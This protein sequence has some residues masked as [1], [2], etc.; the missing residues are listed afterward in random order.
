MLYGISKFK[1]KVAVFLLLSVPV[2]IPQQVIQVVKDNMRSIDTHRIHAVRTNLKEVFPY[3]INSDVFGNFIKLC[4]GIIFDI[5]AISFRKPYQEFGNPVH[6]LWGSVG[7]TQGGLHHNI[8]LGSPII[9]RCPFAGTGELG[10]PVICFLLRLLSGNI[11]ALQ[12]PF[13]ISAVICVLSLY[14]VLIE[15]VS[16]SEQANN[17]PSGKIFFA[18]CDPAGIRYAAGYNSVERIKELLI[19]QEFIHDF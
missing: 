17:K 13:A 18:V 1:N 2:V 14:D 10:V 4:N 3:C 5:L 19:I 7:N 9:C 8:G 12:A 16:G 6:Y 15:Q 11:Q